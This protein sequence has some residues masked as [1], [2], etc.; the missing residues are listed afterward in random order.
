MTGGRRKGRTVPQ[1]GRI[2]FASFL[3]QFDLQ[4]WKR[5]EAV[6]TIA[7]EKK[8]EKGEESLL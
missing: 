8:V 4:V 2:L 7:A 5:N 3:P 6:D 1:D